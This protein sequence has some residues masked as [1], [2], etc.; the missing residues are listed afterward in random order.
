MRF[1][2]RAFKKHS[3][4]IID[5]DQGIRPARP[6]LSVLCAV[7]STA[8]TTTP[9]SPIIHCSNSFTTH[10]KSSVRSTAV[11]NSHR[12][13]WKNIR[14]TTVRTAQSVVRTIVVKCVPRTRKC[15][16]CTSRH[17]SCTGSTVPHAFCPFW[18]ENLRATHASRSSTWQS[19]SLW[20]TFVCPVSGSYRYA[21][22]VNRSLH[23]S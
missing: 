13:K 11:S 10:S 2:S 19:T 22:R 18:R 17:V 9:L 23:S 20:S 8:R 3:K 5:T 16:R 14:C 15:K 21:C 6:V 7:S 1:A 12:T 4:T